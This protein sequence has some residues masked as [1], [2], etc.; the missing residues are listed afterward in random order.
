MVLFYQSKSDDELS[1]IEI[2]KWL[3]KWTRHGTHRFGLIVRS[4]VMRKA[5]TWASTYELYFFTLVYLV[6]CC[7]SH[8]LYVRILEDSLHF[9]SRLI[10]Y[11]IMKIYVEIKVSGAL[12]GLACC[13]STRTFITMSDNSNLVQMY[14]FHSSCN[15]HDKFT[16]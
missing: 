5:V 6:H 8:L 9:L 12:V 7:R 14:N 1:V 3:S 10:L 15:I 2:L 4:K 13:T 16:E 11:V